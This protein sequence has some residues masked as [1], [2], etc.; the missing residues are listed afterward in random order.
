[1]LITPKLTK[2]LTPTNSFRIFVFRPAWKWR[3]S[4]SWVHFSMLAGWL[5]EGAKDLTNSWQSTT[6]IQM[7]S[8]SKQEGWKSS[9]KKFRISATA[10]LHQEVKGKARDKTEGI[11]VQTSPLNTPCCHCSSDEQKS[12]DFPKILQ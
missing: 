4:D 11:S 6:L 3:F 7:S 9:V 8:Q 12:S 2:Y 5:A 1:M 10:D